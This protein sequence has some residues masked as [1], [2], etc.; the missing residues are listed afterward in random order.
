ME[1]LVDRLSP[2]TIT[3]PAV[4]N[5]RLQEMRAREGRSVQTGGSFVNWGRRAVYSVCK[6]CWGG[7]FV[8]HKLPNTGAKHIQAKHEQT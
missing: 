2:R 1:L 7:E 8:T 6:L 4:P 5:R 3:L